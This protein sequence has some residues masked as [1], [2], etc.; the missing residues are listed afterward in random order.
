MKSKML[1]LG[2]LLLALGFACEIDHGLGLIESGISGRVIF[3]HPEQKPARI[4][5]VRVVAVVNFPPQSLGDLV[6]TNTSINLS[7]PAPTYRVPA[8]LAHYVLVGAIYREKGK[9]WDYAKILGFYGSNPDSNL[10]DIKPVT[11][12]KAQ[13]VAGNIDIYCDWAAVPGGAR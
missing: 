12:S 9:E 11:L 5:A 3:L 2:V 8:P 10:Y 1:L 4:D 13:P 6:F 7:Q